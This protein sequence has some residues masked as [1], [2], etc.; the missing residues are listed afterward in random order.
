MQSCS[1]CSCLQS[2]VPQAW[3]RYYETRIFSSPEDLFGSPDGSSA[4]KQRLLGSNGAPSPMT[5]PDLFAS[6][7]SADLDRSGASGRYDTPTAGSYYAGSATSSP[8]GRVGGTPRRVFDRSFDYT[9]ESY[10]EGDSP[11]SLGASTVRYDDIGMEDLG[12]GSGGAATGY[13]GLA[14]TIQDSLLHSANTNRAGRV[15]RTASVDAG[16]GPAS[17]TGKSPVGRSSTTAAGIPAPLLRSR[18]NVAN[19]KCEFTNRMTLKSDEKTASRR[20]QLPF[21]ICLS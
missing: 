2:P 10:Q 20:G 19:G 3:L 9:Q 5:L 1:P 7:A 16:L 4:K 14:Q 15:E 13:A 6:E 17:D 12:S 21:C 18:A 8:A 11:K